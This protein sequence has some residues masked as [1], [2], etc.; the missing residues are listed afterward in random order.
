MAGE[1]A[2]LPGGV[3]NVLTLFARILV[4][5]KA[6]GTAHTWP[7]GGAPYLCIKQKT[8][9]AMLAAECL[10]ANGWRP[11][12]WQI[13]RWIAAAVG[14]GAL[15]VTHRD[16]RRNFWGRLVFASN[17]Y[18]FAPWF[19]AALSKAVDHADWAKAERRL[20]HA[21]RAGLGDVAAESFRPRLSAAPQA[22]AG[23]AGA[24]ACSKS[25]TK[26]E[27]DTDLCAESRSVQGERGDG[28]PSPWG[29]AKVKAVAE[30]LTRGYDL[31]QALTILEFS[32]VFR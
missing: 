20:Y 9:S 13:A 32:T 8:I 19:E 29:P 12:R 16:P 7:D 3:R 27:L 21:R 23:D 22:E 30:L 5:A 28:T 31:R 26:Q 18:Q 11:S 2:E 14:A 15:V 17:L 6:Q 24:L 4:R 10:T 1:L 25:A